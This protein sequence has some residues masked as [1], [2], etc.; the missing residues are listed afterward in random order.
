MKTLELFSSAELPAGLEQKCIQALQKVLQAHP[1]GFVSIP[2]NDAMWTSAEAAGKE[3]LFH[4][5]KLVLCGIGGSSMGAHVIAHLAHDSRLIF[6]ENIDGRSLDRLRKSLNFEETGFLFISKSGNTAETLASLDY[7]NQEM[8]SRGLKLAEHAFVMTESAENS[9]GSW[10]VKNGVSHLLLSK[11]IGG[12]YSVL[13]PVGMVPAAFEG[14]DLAKYRA[15]AQRGLAQTELVAKLMAH[16]SLSF[17]RGEWITA[18]WSYDD[19]GKSIGAWFQQLWAESLGKK[20][21]KD[22]GP[23]KRAST[24]LALVGA[25]DQHSILQQFMEGARDKFVIFLRTES[26]ETGEIKLQSSL[27]KET[28]GLVGHPIGRLMMAE[29]M[30]TEQALR[31]E[32]VASVTLKAKVLDEEGLGEL[33]MVFQMLVAGLGE[34][35]GLDP[36]DQPGVELGK[37]LA[38]EFLAR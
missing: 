14:Q 37:R 34:F 29:A 9:L 13:S 17:E 2:G 28:A 10:A 16:C 6:L 11:T 21:S 12:R 7:L 1:N 36:F 30:A 27:F 25:V 15:G 24:P 20:V 32:G 33:F 38:R 18:L 19:T 8:N 5:K 4:Y 35:L 26:A 31:Q 3:L 23:A 22:G